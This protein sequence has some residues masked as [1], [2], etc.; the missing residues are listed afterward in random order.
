[1]KTLLTKSGI[2]DLAKEL[3]YYFE[4]N[5]LWSQVCIYAAEKS[6]SSYY[7]P[8]SIKKEENQT[9]FYEKDEVDVSEKVEY[10]NPQTITITFEGPLY[11]MINYQDADFVYNLSKKFLYPHHLYFEQGHAWSMAAYNI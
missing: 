3:M 4:Q 2:E 10:C 7:V 9:I 11:D 5:D 1:M 6:F 8:G